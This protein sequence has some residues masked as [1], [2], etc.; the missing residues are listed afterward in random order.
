MKPHIISY[1]QSRIQ[2]CTFFLGKS[3][4]AWCMMCAEDTFPIVV[5]FCQIMNIIYLFDIAS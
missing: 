1:H 5:R 2:L 3:P 4:Y